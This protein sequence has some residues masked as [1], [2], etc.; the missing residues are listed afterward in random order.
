[1]NSSGRLRFTLTACSLT[2][3]A[4]LGLPAI[5]TA[6]ITDIDVSGGFGLGFIQ[7]GVGCTYTV[8]ATG[9]P[10]DSVAFADSV[11]GRP[12]GGTFGPVTEEEPG[13]FTADWNPTA[14]GEHLLSADGAT[15]EV[16]VHVGYDFGLVCFTLPEWVRLP[17]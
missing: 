10:G 4:V 7:Y 9:A 2:T 15:T 11:D 12:G 16:D 6:A 17:F 14:I 8:T 5:A 13:V 1:M 3:A